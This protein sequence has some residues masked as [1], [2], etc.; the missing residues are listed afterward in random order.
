MEVDHIIP[1]I[2]GGKD[3][4]DNLQLLHGHCHDSKTANDGSNSQKSKKMDSSK[5]KPTK[6]NKSYKPDKL[7]LIAIERNRP[8][9]RNKK[10][11]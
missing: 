9:L 2:L 7:D 3:T 5:G 1:R 4:Y 11:Q 6:G 8:V 10:L